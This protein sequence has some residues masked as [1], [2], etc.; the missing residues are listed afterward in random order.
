MRFLSVVA[1]FLI[2][3]VAFAEDKKLTGTF[4]KKAE[5]FDLKLGFPKKDMVQITMDNGTEGCV[6]DAKF[7][8]DKDG[9]IKCEVTKFEKKGG[10]PV[11]KDVGYK[12]SFKIDVK[13]K[14]AKVTEFTG[15]GIDDA[16]KNVLEGNYDKAGD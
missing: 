13:G 5:G 12:F 6:L 16:A 9:T 11:S 15:D 4:G 3:G 8:T 2:T 10:F 7:T 1:L 14:T